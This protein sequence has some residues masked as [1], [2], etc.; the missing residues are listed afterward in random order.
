MSI[1]LGK[2]RGL[3][4]CS[5]EEAVFAIL[6][7]DHRNNLRRVLCPDHPESVSNSE[8]I[9]FKQDVLQAVAPHASGVLLDPEVGAPH[10]IATDAIQVNIGLIIALEATGYTGDTSNRLSQVLDKWSVGKIKR[11]GASAVKLLV[12]YHPE[13]TEAAQQEEL[14]REIGDRCIDLD[15]AFFLEPLSFSLDPNQKLSSDEKR[16]VVLETARKLTPLGVD[17]LK[18]EFPIIIDEESNEETWLEA[19]RELTTISNVPWVLLSAGVGF[20]DFL[21]QAFIAMKAGASGVLAGR[22]I[23]GEAVDYQGSKRI[24]FLQTTAAERMAKL[25]ASCAAH[26][27]PW[28]ENFPPEKVSPKWYETYK[29]IN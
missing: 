9:T 13:A 1:S 24:E 20:D 19:C 2:R 28:I 17:V 10:A 11:L 18:A 14:V 8:M 6:A 12:Y 27:K 26:A 23:W 15:I 4:Q 16:S 3:A 7:L 22:A 25:R 21:R 5:T 29:D